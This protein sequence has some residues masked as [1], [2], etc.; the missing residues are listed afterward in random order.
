VHQNPKRYLKSSRP[1]T[2]LRDSKTA[3]LTP[4]WNFPQ[5]L[6]IMLFSEKSKFYLESSGNFKIKYQGIAKNYNRQVATYNPESER[7]I[8]LQNIWARCHKLHVLFKK[9]FPGL[10]ERGIVFQSH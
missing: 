10:G 3:S 8:M 1:A 9:H 4:I 6:N 7:K 2:V 5:G